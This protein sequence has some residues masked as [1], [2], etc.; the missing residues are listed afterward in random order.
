[1]FDLDSGA[2][3]QTAVGIRDRGELPSGRKV[4]GRADFFLGAADV[5]IDPPPGWKPQA[6]AVKLAAGAQ[7]VQTQFCMDVALLRRY[8]ARLAEHGLTEKLSILVGI[9]PLRSVKSARWIKDRLHGS[10]IPDALIARMEA[11]R[12]PAAEGRRIC[13][14]MVAEL[15]GMA[16]VAGCH[17]MAP[18]NE[19]AV[20][21]IIAAA[22]KGIS[23]LAAV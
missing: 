9:V 22:R 8:L 18:G 16:Q 7:F 10:V 2:L 5:P 19:A 15:A 23:R 1:V 17:I 20:P 12:D 11:A 14:D 4:G 6:L 13:L 3:I 21:D